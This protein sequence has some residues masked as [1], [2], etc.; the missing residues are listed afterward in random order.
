LK[1]IVLTLI[2]TLLSILGLTGCVQYHNGVPIGDKGYTR[3]FTFAKDEQGFKGGFADLPVNYN[4]Y[5]Y[6]LAFNQASVPIKDKLDK[7]LMLKGHNRS[8]DLFMYVSKK[9]SIR[10]GLRP[11]TKYTVL[12]KFDLA[13]NVAGGGMGIGGSPGASVYVKAGIINKEPL[14]DDINGMKIIN[15]DKGIQANGGTEMQVLGNIEKTESTDDSF[16]YKHFENNIV[17]TTN[18]KGEVWLI[19]GTDSGF[20]GLTQIYLTNIKLTANLYSK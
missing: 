18:D 10:D 11:N 2:L 13:T 19:I 1:K 12:L 8:D 16:E 20:E 7:G 6:T 15:V 9:F 4:P 14:V 3:T 5:I 17:V